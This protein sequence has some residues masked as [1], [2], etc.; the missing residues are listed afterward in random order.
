MLLTKKWEGIIILPAA[1][2][3]ALLI[4]QWMPHPHSHPATE[5][6]SPAAVIT[7]YSP[8]SDEQWMPHQCP[9]VEPGTPTRHTNCI[10]APV[11]IYV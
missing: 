3:A 9:G 4:A 11:T 6:S 1:A 5:E 10:E 7:T 2:Y 8:A